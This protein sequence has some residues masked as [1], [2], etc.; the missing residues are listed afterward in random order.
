MGVKP[1]KR[2]VP[3]MKKKMGKESSF[4]IKCNKQ[5]FQ[6]TYIPC[7]KLTVSLDF[8][9]DQ[10]SNQKIYRELLYLCICI[11]LMWI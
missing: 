1:L 2:V 4:S 8:L 3:H 11:I 9:R 5:D 10:S 7:Y 6:I